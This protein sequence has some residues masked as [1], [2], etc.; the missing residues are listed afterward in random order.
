[1]EDFILMAPPKSKV[2]DT[3]SGDKILQGRALREENAKKKLDAELA[4]G[5]RETPVSPGE[6]AQLNLDFAP[7]AGGI[8]VST[9]KPD[10]RPFEEIHDSPN[11]PQPPSVSSGDGRTA[12]QFQAQQKVA[13]TQPEVARELG[14]TGLVSQNL[15]AS[16]SVRNSATKAALTAEGLFKKIE[17]GKTLS[18]ADVALAQQ[19]QLTD[20]DIAQIKAGEAHIS[21]IEEFVDSVPI[22]GR[23]K[24]V[25]P[26]SIGLNDFVTDTP[27]DKIDSLLDSM[28]A[29]KTNIAAWTTEIKANPG[30]AATYMPMIEKQEEEIRKLESKIKLMSLQQVKVQSNPQIY[31]DIMKEINDI[32]TKTG[33]AKTDLQLLGIR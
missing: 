32:L 23:R 17:E 11:V 25:G 31:D 13:Q 21:R 14:Q 16:Q 2:P 33:S 12:A 20:L 3:R 1:M 28:Q 10:P 29:S 15:E 22:L 26:V 4:A 30:K 27:S 8:L 19:L 24:R 18:E 9:G 5:V 6:R 7:S